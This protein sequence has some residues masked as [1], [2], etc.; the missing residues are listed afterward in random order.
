MEV[1]YLSSYLL[2]ILSFT[3]NNTIKSKDVDQNNLINDVVNKYPDLVQKT[4]DNHIKSIIKKNNHAI[5]KIYGSQ[6]NSINNNKKNNLPKNIKSINEHSS[7][8]YSGFFISSDGYI[9]SNYSLLKEYNSLYIEPTDSKNMGK[10]KL[11]I[12]GYDEYAD[13]IILKA[14]IKT[15]NFISIN[16]NTKNEKVSNYIYPIQG[17]ECKINGYKDIQYNYYNNKNH[18]HNNSERYNFSRSYSDFTP[19]ALIDINGHFVGLKVFNG[20]YKYNKLDYYNSIIPSNK[21][22]P[23]IN[24]IREK[25]YN[26]Y[27]T[28][29]FNIS[30]VNDKK[31]KFKKIN[32][33]EGCYIEKINNENLKKYNL[34]QGDIIIGIN[35]YKIYDINS[36]EKIFNKERN[37]DI[38]FEIIQSGKNNKILVPS[39]IISDIKYEYK[40]KEL[41]IAGAQLINLTKQQ[42]ESINKKNKFDGGV[43]ISKFLKKKNWKCQENFVITKINRQR[44]YTTEDIVM[45]LKNIN[46]R[47]NS[48]KVEI[49][50]I[51]I[52]GF[53]IEETIKERKCFALVL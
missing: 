24:C 12:V 22:I 8:E 23:I 15:Q 49:E 13:I 53:Y 30:A 25:G 48:D 35:N 9:I 21:V 51:F 32:V 26:I 52:E 10:L 38:V 6:D 4:L 1:R 40:N 16:E 47:L 11:N 14:N 19:L 18:K 28:S 46:T 44:V 3:F 41:F 50:P 17:T 39:G 33:S 27:E 34:K 36:F 29:D 31:K 5:V 45:I 42:I 7:I 20:K 2:L 37:N 43:L